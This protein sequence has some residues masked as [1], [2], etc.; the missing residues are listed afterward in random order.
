MNDGRVCVCER[1]CVWVESSKHYLYTKQSEDIHTLGGSFS[2]RKL[3]AMF[4]E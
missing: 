2:R 1:V 3:S 4:S